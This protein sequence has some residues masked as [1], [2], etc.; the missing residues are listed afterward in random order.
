MHMAQY[1]SHE[2]D[3]H[4][5]FFKRLTLCNILLIDRARFA[6]TAMIVITVMDI[7]DFADSV[8]PSHGAPFYGAADTV[9]CLFAS[10]NGGGARC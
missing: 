2:Q 6:T 3:A 5:W 1:C 4:L 9:V 7:L 10:K 8:A